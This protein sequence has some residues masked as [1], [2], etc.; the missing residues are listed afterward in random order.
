MVEVVALPLVTKEVQINEGVKAVMKEKA[1]V[2][3]STVRTLEDALKFVD[4]QRR[5]K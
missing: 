5:A 1:E 4:E 3:P 2:E